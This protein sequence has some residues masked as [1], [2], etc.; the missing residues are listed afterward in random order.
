[1]RVAAGG[2]AAAAIAS[3]IALAGAQSMSAPAE[4]PE[5]TVVLEPATS[6]PAPVVETAQPDPQR[7][8]TAVTGGA[9]SGAGK[10]PV[11][12]KGKPGKATPQDKAG[13]P[14][15]DKTTS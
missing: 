15:K 6:S 12:A 4:T 1:R 13:P 8:S 14:A 7:A 3:I 9:D 5:Q 10:S 11:K 2:I